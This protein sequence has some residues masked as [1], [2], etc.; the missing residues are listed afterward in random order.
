MLDA[1]PEELR[2]FI[3]EAREHLHK[4]EESILRLERDGDDEHVIAELFR[5][6]HTL[7]GSSATLGLEP[8]AVLTHRLEDILDRVRSG[9]TEVSEQVVNLLFQGHDVL[10]RMVDALDN[11]EPVMQDEGIIAEMDRYLSGTQ[12]EVT[13]RHSESRETGTGAPRS[14]H[15]LLVE[16]RPD[17][18][19]PSVRMFQVVTVLSRLAEVTAC[20]PDISSMES[21]WE[22]RELTVDLYYEGSEQEL[23][24]AASS[25]LEVDKVRVV[26]KRKEMDVKKGDPRTHRTVRV[27]V[28]L[29]D[30][31]MNLVGELVID[32]TRLQ[33]IKERLGV[34]EGAGLIADDLSG[35]AA[36]IE[37]TTHGLQEGIMKVRMMPVHTLFR[38]FPRMVR[39][40]A[41]TAGK[42][43]D[44]IMEGEDT[45]L[46]RFLIEEIGD[47][48][49]HLLRNAIDHGIEPPDLRTA[50]GKPRT[51]TLLLRAWH[52]ENHVC[53][54][55]SDDGRG[56]DTARVRQKAVEKGLITSDEAA[57]MSDTEAIELIFVPGF[58]TSDKVSQVS[59]RG[60]G[61]DV[62]RQNIEAL[63][64]S[65]Y[66][67]STQQG[68]SFTIRI[69]LTLAIIRAL[70]VELDAQTYAIPLNTVV[71][72]R[73]IPRSEVFRMRG[74]DVIEVRGK[75][76]PLVSLK[77]V[78]FAVQQPHPEK[79]ATVIVNIGGKQAGLVVDGLLREEEV[80]IKNIGALSGKVKGI[81]GAT[82]L[83]EGNVALI[84]DIPHI[85][86]LA[87]SGKTVTHGTFQVIQASA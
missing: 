13:A 51:G 38:K 62:V 49:I 4:M 43:V 71:E 75:L 77:E 10:L 6:A 17:C 3:D 34:L 58:S 23:V 22:G 39:E 44:F 60:V 12:Q 31:L 81:A 46:D 26:A 14:T 86:A 72:A 53:I 36:R 41:R 7:K 1:T 19:M 55:V 2:V 40:L 76:M 67:Q 70:L 87:G 42:E 68:A 27:D 9:Q 84:P 78:F 83:G 61:L 65:V 80:V 32:R 50:A 45:E 54:R 21:G 28:A 79:I 29:L 85:L 57:R 74:R 56:I 66:V 69:P 20:N 63:N 30:A 52:E 25:V 15:T 11:Q 73:R 35:I 82:I 5:S 37:R 33:S 47:P 59:G 64:G 24:A 48:L 18:V 8:M 16:L